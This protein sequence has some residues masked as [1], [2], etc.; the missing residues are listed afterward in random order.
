MTKPRRWLIGAIALAVV[1]VSFAG[2]GLYRLAYPPPRELLHSDSPD[3]RYRLVVLEEVPEGPLAQS[4]YLYYMR[5]CDRATGRAL[6]GDEPVVW[7][8]DSCATPVDDIKVVWSGTSV[9][10]SATSPG[11][12]LS[13]GAVV[14]GKQ[15]W[16]QDTTRPDSPTR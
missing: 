4:P 8:G 16:R 1:V 9:T 2:W 5:I 11:P 7:N 13:Q 6:P 3:G 10:V 14:D 12:R 15:I